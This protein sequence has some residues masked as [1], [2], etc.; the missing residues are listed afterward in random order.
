MGNRPYT[1]AGA[2]ESHKYDDIIDRPHYV[3]PTRPQMSM[4]ERAAQFSPFD[5]LTGYDESIEETAR[6][7]DTRTPLSEQQLA[8][9]DEA[10]TRL[11]SLCREAARA[12]FAG[13]EE[14]LP[15]V[16]LTWFVPDAVLHRGSGKSGGS[17]FTR[18][19]TV[20]RV[21][22]AAG[23]LS[24]LEAS[25]ARGEQQIPL[26]DVEKIEGCTDG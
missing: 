12:R 1:W 20:R 2:E 16:T 10:L 7:T 9:L 24:I 26:G 3:S 22:R 6:R 11:E 14:R 13:E 19:V 18:R 8:A 21:D 25:R 4:L 23:T 15:Q 17:F 5:A